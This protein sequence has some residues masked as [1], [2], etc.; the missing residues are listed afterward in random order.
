MIVRLGDF[1]YRCLKVLNLEN[2]IKVSVLISYLLASV[3]CSGEFIV[4]HAP[5]SIQFKGQEKLD[6]SLLKEVYSAALGQPIFQS[7]KWSGM[8]FTDPFNLAESIVTIAVDG[9]T[10]L[11]N[12]KGISFP[13][14]ADE[15]EADVFGALETRIYEQD[16]DAQK[17]II[18]IDLSQGLDSIQSYN[19]LNDIK[20]VEPEKQYKHL[21][22]GF[23][24]DRQFINELQLLNAITEKIE[25]GAYQRSPAPSVFWFKFSAYKSVVNFHG[26]NSTAANEAKVLLLDAIARLQSAFKKLYSGDV[27]VNVLTNEISHKRVARA[28][29]NEVK[30]GSDSFDDLNLASTYN[31]NFPVI[32][33]IILWFSVIMAF[34]L[35]AISVVIGDMDPGR[36]SIIY[37]MTS[38][39]M[40]KEN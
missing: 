39:R 23:K 7:S 18:R 10:D 36:D 9:I 25:S 3:Y 38:T 12:G 14:N 16:P 26:E 40:K 6:E 4:L 34:T 35:L 5:K 20:S 29:S 15:S 24:E 13:L 22:V 32:F 37:R 27:L 2:M 31:E 8:Y 11:D 33:N 30:E 1:H 17:N 19:F 28:T 21:K